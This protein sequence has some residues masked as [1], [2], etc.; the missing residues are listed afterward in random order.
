MRLEG[1]T[2][3]ITGGSRGIG[4][5]VALAFARAGAHLALV[6]RSTADLERVAG[7]GR[8][9]G[10]RVLA[11]SADVSRRADVERATALAL[12]AFEG[13]DVVVNAAGIYG[14]IGPLAECGMD[15]WAAAIETNLLGTAFTLRAVLPGMIARRKGCVINFSGG[16]AVN[17]FPRFSAYSASKAA[18]VRLTETVAE[19]VQEYGVRV[20]AIAPGAVNTRMLDEAL[21]AGEQRVGKEFYAKARKQKSLGGTPPEHAAELALFLA[22]PEAAGITGRLISAVWD[23][24]KSLAGRGA[25]LAGS[26]MFTLRRI[27]GRNFEE[28]H[29]EVPR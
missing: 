21:A 5:A 16:G 15:G 17:P 10:V 24:W 23:D 14:P 6:A 20:N 12:E 7:A 2:V 4:K 1:K 13:I 8:E 25:E 19:E 27:D 29:A 18:V 22:S 3:F 28:V 9:L 11:V 26:A